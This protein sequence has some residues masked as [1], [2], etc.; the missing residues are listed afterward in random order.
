MSSPK[1]LVSGK[2]SS[3]QILSELAVPLATGNDTKYNPYVPNPYDTA[4]L[5]T[6]SKDSVGSSSFKSEKLMT[7]EEYNASRKGSANTTSKKNS[8]KSNVDIPINDA[9][10]SQ[11]DQLESSKK[12]LVNNET[13]GSMDGHI[14]VFVRIRPIPEEKSMNE[15][16][17]LT[18]Y[19]DGKSVNCRMDYDEKSF[20]FQK[21]FDTEATQNDIFDSVRDSIVTPIFDGFNSCILSYGQ[22]GSGKT[23]TMEGPSLSDNRLAGITPRSVNYIYDRIA[24]QRN[25]DPN[26]IHEITVSLY[27]IYCEKINDLLNVENEN[28]SVRETKLGWVVKNITEVECATRESL[29][30]FLEVGNHNRKV[31]ATFMNAESSR[32]HR[33]FSLTLI[34]KNVS[35]KLMRRGTLF[36]V[37]LAGSEKVAK[38]GVTGVRLEEAKKI[39]TSLST[40]GQVIQALCN[41]SNFVPYR[42]SK[43]TL[44]LR[45]ALGGNSKTALI[46]CCSSEKF[47]AA[48]TIST[49]RFGERARKVKTHLKLNETYD[50]ISVQELQAQLLIA[51]E[52]IKMLREKVAHLEA[53]NSFNI[54]NNAIATTTASNKPSPHKSGGRRKSVKLTLGGQDTDDMNNYLATEENYNEIVSWLMDAKM[55]KCD[56]EDVADQFK[57]H[58]IYII[59]QLVLRLAQD[60]EFLEGALELDASNVS[61]IQ[62]AI[63]S[64][65]NAPL[66]KVQDSEI[67]DDS[68]NNVDFFEET[69][70][71]F[72]GAGVGITNVF[73]TVGGT[74]G[75]T[76]GGIFGW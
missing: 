26:I 4:S 13:H 76:I 55:S 24:S 74:I 42:D 5:A 65:R 15:D 41:D 21:I 75:G 1:K 62:E 33:I 28:L 34:T 58:S 43:L 73:S 11:Y 48:E 72:V 38:T 44:V 61:T 64:W 70:K 53:S 36:L 56:A 39:N 6:T 50:N 45:N 29:F 52:E 31:A 27:E 7:R 18:V 46:I 19:N 67:E 40:L 2:Q 69:G 37:D 30:H 25:V 12:T 47:N 16:N 10:H 57:E 20:T 51:N 14:N 17:I 54:I 59:P 9:P 63:D 3:E 60:P 32:S 35:T 71:F 68:N 23:F 66:V 22:T 8:G 49:L